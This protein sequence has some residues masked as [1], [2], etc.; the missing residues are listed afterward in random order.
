[1]P[2]GVTVFGDCAIT[3]RRQIAA[4]TSGGRSSFTTRA[5]LAY[6]ELPYCTG[7]GIRMFPP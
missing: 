7:L 2:V 5:R 4:T 3:M 6:A 1:M